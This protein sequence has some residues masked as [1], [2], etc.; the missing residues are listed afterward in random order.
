M[1]SLDAWRDLRYAQRDGLHGRDRR[2]G[3]VAG[4]IDPMAAFANDAA[5]ADLRI[6]RPMVVRNIAGVDQHVHDR[7]L[8]PRGQQMR[9]S[10]QRAAKNGD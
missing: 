7:R 1:L 4:Q 8:R 5:A 2:A 10:S 9:G 3:Q 6:L